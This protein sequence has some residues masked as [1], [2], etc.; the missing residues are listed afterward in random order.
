MAWFPGFH[1]AFTCC[2]FGA[3]TDSKL[4]SSNFKLPTDISID[5]PIARLTLPRF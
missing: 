4:E 1:P 3:R 5:S 2:P